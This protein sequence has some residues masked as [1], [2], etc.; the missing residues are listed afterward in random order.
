MIRTAPLLKQSCQNYLN[1]TGMAE[2][3]FPEGD[4]NQDHWDGK[5]RELLS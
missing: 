3:D 1:R 5:I 2:I 4:P